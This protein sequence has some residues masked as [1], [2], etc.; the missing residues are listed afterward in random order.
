[1]TRAFLLANAATAPAPIAAAMR[2][3]VADPKNATAADTLSASP[4][5]I[6]QVRTTCVVTQIAGGHAPNALP[7][8]ATA[9]VNCRIFPGTSRA[10]VQAK[11]VQL[12]ADPKV[13]VTFRDNGTLETG[14]SPLS[15]EVMTAVKRA[16]TA[17]APGIPIVPAM[18][19]GATD[20]M[21]FRARG[22]PAYGVGSVFIRAEDVFAHGLNER[23]PV[24]TL[25]PGVAHWEALLR[26]L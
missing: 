20:S 24:A 23:V 3:F 2:A 15:A 10:T 26:S 25:D 22:I 11:L 8:S 18:S 6:G 13:T 5:Y 7:Q 4:E 16:V 19:A 9:N 17:R 12:V 1:V 14:A 21:H